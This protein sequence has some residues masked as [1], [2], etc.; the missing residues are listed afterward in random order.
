MYSKL[1]D[2]ID[3][4]TWLK[5]TRHNVLKKRKYIKEKVDQ[6]K[7]QKTLIAKR[8]AEKIYDENVSKVKKTIQDLSSK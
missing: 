2:V 7:K 6:V 3:V 1:R 5:P 8:R 4:G